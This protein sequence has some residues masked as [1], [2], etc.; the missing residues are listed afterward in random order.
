V[1]VKLTRVPRADARGYVLPPY[2]LGK[3]ASAVIAISVPNSIGTGPVEAFV[4]ICIFH[5][6]PQNLRALN[7]APCSWTLDLLTPLVLRMPPPPTQ[8]DG[9]VGRLEFNNA[10]GT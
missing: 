4:A 7:D 10:T 9:G 8:S 5:H 2:G 1:P 6:S 3:C